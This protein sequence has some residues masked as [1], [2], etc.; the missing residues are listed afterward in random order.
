MHAVGASHRNSHWHVHSSGLAMK[1]QQGYRRFRRQYRHLLASAK[2]E[3]E[4]PLQKSLL[5]TIAAMAYNAGF[6]APRDEPVKQAKVRSWRG[7]NTPEIR[8]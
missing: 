8:T 4:T 2:R 3:M 1:V 5:D 6:N 7:R